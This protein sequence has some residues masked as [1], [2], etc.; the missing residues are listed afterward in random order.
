MDNKEHTAALS[1]L[2]A[3][4]AVTRKLDQAA[5][6]CDA[7]RLALSSGADMPDS[8]GDALWA[9]RD[10]IREAKSDAGVVWDAAK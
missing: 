1:A 5:G 4:D 8:I 3:M 9:A 2:G 7:V 10:I 6:I